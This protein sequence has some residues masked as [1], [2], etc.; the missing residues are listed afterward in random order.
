MFFKFHEMV[1]HS[2]VSWGQKLN[3]WNISI[4]RTVKEIDS[5]WVGLFLRGSGDHKYFLFIPYGK[6]S[7]CEK[8]VVI[9]YKLY[10]TSS[11]GTV[12]YP[13]VKEHCF[14]Q[15]LWRNVQTNLSKRKGVKPTV[16]S[17][18]SVQEPI[19]YSK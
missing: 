16:S 1:I 3:T 4:Q 5:R 6:I 9:L 8:E 18:F 19:K 14:N 13:A 11:L 7:I 2:Q 12:N 10:C 15:D 17:F